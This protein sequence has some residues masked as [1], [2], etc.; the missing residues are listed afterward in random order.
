[1]LRVRVKQ[2][3]DTLEVHHDEDYFSSTLRQPHRLQRRKTNVSRFGKEGESSFF[4]YILGCLCFAVA[5]ELGYILSLGAFSN[6]EFW[7]FYFGS[8]ISSTSSSLRTSSTIRPIDHYYSRPHI[9]DPVPLIVG[10]SDGSGTR[11]FA[12]ILEH[13]GVPILVEDRGTMDVHAKEMYNGEGWPALVTRVLNVTRSA[14]YDIQ[15]IPEPML[16][17]AREE[18]GKFVTSLK[19]AG[20]ALVGAGIGKTWATSVSWAFKAPISILLLPLF[21]EKLPALKVLH[22]VRDGRDVALSDNHS[23]V[24]KFYTYFYKDAETRHKALLDQ[25]EFQKDD[26]THIKAMQL[27]NDWNKQIYDYGLR[28]SDGKTLDVLVMRTEDLMRYPL[29]SVVLLADF[30]GSM[31]TSHQLCCLSRM[32]AT[33]LGQSGGNPFEDAFEAGDENVG[34]GIRSLRRFDPNDF[35]QIR[36]RFKQFVAP[37]DNAEAAPDT[38]RR[39]LENENSPGIKDTVDLFKTGGKLASANHPAHLLHL[40]VVD[41]QLQ[42]RAVGMGDPGFSQVAQIQQ[43]LHERRITAQKSLQAPQ[44]EDHV[45]MRYGKWVKPLQ[46]NP[47]LSDRLH[48]EGRDTL[49]LFGY[50]P[51]RE[52]MDLY[53]NPDLL[54]TC[55]STVMCSLP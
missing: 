26:R 41:E 53:P 1:M 42:Q 28:Y 54:P 55:D 49:S 33:D 12:Q 39:L 47:V 21:R 9:R 14:S 45:K 24:Q 16:Q 6:G 35:N 13:L 11:A 43:L 20:A 3:S 7:S 8:T 51:M 46:E 22:I 2:K 50:E 38:R 32:S 25:Q 4:L 5:V 17:S 18:V 23:P 29:E 34:D 44:S 10:G 27:W 19:F 15:D 36:N 31:K 30:V 52:F 40:Q 48:E 37:K